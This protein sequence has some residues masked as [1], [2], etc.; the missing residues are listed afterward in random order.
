[1]ILMQMPLDCN[2]NKYLTI[3]LGTLDLHPCLEIFIMV[4][5]PHFYLTDENLQNSIKGIFPDKDL[6]CSRIYFDLVLI[7]IDIL[8]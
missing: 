3:P 1:M 8:I 6:H 2:D 7:W 5:Q 4:S